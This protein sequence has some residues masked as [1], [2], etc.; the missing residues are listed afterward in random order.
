[1]YT[2]IDFEFNQA[3]DFEDKPTVFNPDCRF[4]IIQ[5]GAV[6]LNDSLD[7]VDKISIL[8]KPQLYTRMHPYVE[9][10]TGI[11]IDMLEDKPT[12]S[13]A[14]AAFL[15]FIGSSKILCVWGNSDIRALYRN[16]TYHHI[17]E[18]PILIQYVDVQQLTTRHLKYSR[19]G[20]VGL[21]NAVEMLNLPIDNTLTFHDAL[22]DAIYTAKVFKAIHLDNIV[23]KVFN[24]NHIK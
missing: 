6:K 14:F 3:F 10:I 4:E 19:G 1:M 7:I 8:I 12:F 9:K 22:S 2:V 23:I 24:S 18:P 13:E 20:T 16:I 5:I 15:D 17:K 21:K 11:T